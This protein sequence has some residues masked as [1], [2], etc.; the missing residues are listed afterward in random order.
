[1]FVNTK[2][3]FVKCYNH[4]VPNWKKINASHLIEDTRLS[5]ILD[6]IEKFIIDNNLN[7]KR[8]VDSIVDFYYKKNNRYPH[9][10]LFKGGTAL[11]IYK[12]YTLPQ[13]LDLSELQKIY[14]SV[15]KSN[16]LLKKLKSYGIIYYK[17]VNSLHV[18]GKADFYFLLAHGITEGIP[19]NIIK[20][21]E[22]SDEIKITVLNAIFS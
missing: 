17:G 15:K 8:L 12:N 21:W 1:M 20:K 4:R 14:V 19:E 13:Q 3:L 22:N 5:K 9:I 11:S 6:S 10:F 16:I 7:Y 2:D 18:T